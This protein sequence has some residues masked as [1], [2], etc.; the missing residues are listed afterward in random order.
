M[1]E[2]FSNT[3]ERLRAALGDDAVYVVTE[4]DAPGA[5]PTPTIVVAPASA[6]QVAETVR[7]AADAGVGIVPVGGDTAPRR[8]RNEDL[9]CVALSLERMSGVVEHAV[10][11]LVLT[12]QAGLVLTEAQAAIAAHGHRVPLAPPLAARATLGGIVA[13]SA[14]G[15]TRNAYGSVRDQVLGIQV[16]HGDGRISR[17]GGRVV[18]NVTGYDLCRLYTG[19]RGVLGVITELTLR[20]RPIEPAACRLAWR[21]PRIEDAWNA[22][23]TLRRDIPALYGL[24]AARG[25]A[26]DGISG[27]GAALVATLRGPEAF[28]EALGAS[29]WEHDLGAASQEVLQPDAVPAI[30]GP[31]SALDAWLRVCVLPADGGRLLTTLAQRI[32]DDAD[33]V[34]DVLGGVCDV[35]HEDPGFLDPVDETA[36][37][38]DLEPLGAQVDCPG[39]PGFHLRR[40]HLFPSTRPGGV[41]VMQAL[42]R[43]LDPAGVLNPGRYEVAP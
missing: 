31:V 16:V 15:P 2:V 25:T 14:E 27:E 35:T 39:D 38:A 13:C 42:M 32:G 28:V 8:A 9:P 19:S 17:A 21:F 43:S 30:I 3:D 6:E 5:L 41:N 10:E 20:L 1:T 36:L 40:L 7:V 34:L 26:T 11:D 4:G 29:C 24:H 23:M 18:K 12:A 33:L 37:G 22:G